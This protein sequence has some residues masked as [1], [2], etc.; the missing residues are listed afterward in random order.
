VAIGGDD[1]LSVAQKLHENDVKVVGVPKTIDNDLGGT[2]YTFGFDT[3]CNVVC[4]A[5][6]RVHTTAEAHN[7][8]IVVEVMGR[9]SGWIAIYSGVAGG[10]D[11]ILIPEQPF[12]I[13][14]IA[15][16]IKSRHDRGRNFSIVVVAEGAKLASR[17]G[18]EE[19]RKTDE[20]GHVRLGGIAN[21]LAA[22]IESRTGFETRAVVL[23]HTQRGGS[24]T[25]FDRM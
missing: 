5:I 14:E 10:A 25:A 12:D 20:F 17:T 8:V 18:E 23:G 3:A 6:D 9:D 4:E 15:E 11:V 7:R 21:S 16:T 24:P 13:Q 2:D 19:R 22:E 1:T